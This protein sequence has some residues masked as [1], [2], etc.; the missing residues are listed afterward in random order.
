MDDADTFETSLQALH[1]L[2]AKLQHVRA[3]APRVLGNRK[4]VVTSVFDSYCSYVVAPDHL[5]PGFGRDIMNLCITLL[6][7][8]VRRDAEAIAKVDLKD[9]YL[10]YQESLINHEKHVLQS[11]T[12]SFITAYSW[13]GITP[14]WGL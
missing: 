14:S 5:F 4:P 9:G 3:R 7:R 11:M 10:I 6:P 1:Q 12:I 13:C 2:S 8:D